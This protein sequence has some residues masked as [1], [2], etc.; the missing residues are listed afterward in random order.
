MSEEICDKCPV[1]DSNR[2]HRKEKCIAYMFRHYPH[3]TGPMQVYPSNCE[4]ITEKRKQQKDFA[5][6][7]TSG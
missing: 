7:K 2:C 1:R 4:N 3:S 5:I 6:K